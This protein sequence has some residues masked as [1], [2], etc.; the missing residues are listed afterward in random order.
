M[1]NLEI[2]VAGVTKIE[3]VQAILQSLALTHGTPIGTLL[4]DHY[5]MFSLDCLVKLVREPKNVHDGNAIAI[6][7]NDMHVGYVPKD[8]AAWL[9]GHIDRGKYVAIRSMSIG[10]GGGYSFGVSMLVLYEEDSE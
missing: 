10:G 7:L 1:I 2:K 3:G 4:P 5:N 9:A 6:Y 8:T